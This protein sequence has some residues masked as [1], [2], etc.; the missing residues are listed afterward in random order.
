LVGFICLG[1]ALAS[2]KGILYKL[3]KKN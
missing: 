2:I 1:V 3:N